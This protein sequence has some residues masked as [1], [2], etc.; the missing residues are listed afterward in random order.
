MMMNGMEKG[1]WVRGELRGY[2]VLH[3]LIWVGIFSDIDHDE[4]K[5]PIS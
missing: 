4:R 5:K 1:L 2:R 3:M